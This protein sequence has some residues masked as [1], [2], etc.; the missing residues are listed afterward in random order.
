MFVFGLFTQVSDSGPQGPLVSPF[1]QFSLFRNEFA[2]DRENSV[3]ESI[4]GPEVIKN[5][6]SSQLSFLLINVEIPT[7]VGILTFMSRKKSIVGLSEPEK[8]S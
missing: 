3:R 2:T 1:K 6:C 5:S 7:V 8:K 4:T